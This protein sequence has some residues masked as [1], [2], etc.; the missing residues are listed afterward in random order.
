MGAV[1][2]NFFEGIPVWLM[3]VGPPGCG[4]TAILES[5]SSI[6]RTRGLQEITGTGSL[7]SGTGQKDKTDQATGGVLREIGLKG[8]LILNEFTS[9]L[10][11]P[12]EQLVKILAA[13][14]MI[15]DGKYSR[16]VGSDGARKL[17]W[18]PGKL[19]A[20]AGCT[21][22]IDDAHKVIADMGERWIFYRFPDSDGYQES[23]AAS[24]QKQP[25][26]ARANIRDIV[27]AFFDS[28]DLSWGNDGAPLKTRR[29]LTLNETQRIIAIST[30]A[31]RCRSAVIRDN[32]TREVERV[33]QP[34][35]APR[36]VEVL[37]QLYIG[38]EAVGLGESDRWAVISRIALDCMP[39][40]RRRALEEIINIRTIAN[41]AA[42]PLRD[43]SVTPKTMA[44]IQAKMR[45]S[46]SAVKRI[47]E[48]L[49]IHGAVARTKKVRGIWTISE[50]T[51]KTLELGWNVRVG[52]MESKESEE[53]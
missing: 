29:D 42:T 12:S 6:P 44:E 10:S 31:T 25:T 2:A 37:T 48:E 3:L 35:R 49:E 19:S 16:D 36:M 24:K 8:T 30:M 52:G 18:G 46:M 34:E 4:K 13:F 20:M 28:L 41:V 17:T 51:R 33:P 5:L 39:Q 22:S 26:Q 53:G 9:I 23:L 43:I 21:E 32:R 50:W 11:M 45:L 47:M 1:A 40:N 7:L 14:R 38:L 27:S 15:Y